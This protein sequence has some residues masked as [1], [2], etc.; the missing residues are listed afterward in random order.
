MTSISSG[1]PPVSIMWTIS[2]RMWSG[3]LRPSKALDLTSGTIFWQD[4]LFSG[5]GADLVEE[6]EASALDRTDAVA[7]VNLGAGSIGTLVVAVGLRSWMRRLARLSTVA[8]RIPALISGA[9]SSRKL[10]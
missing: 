2:S 8:A 9:R 1:W 3:I 10:L 4:G 5:S 7:E 6:K